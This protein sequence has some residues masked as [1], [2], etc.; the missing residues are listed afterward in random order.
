MDA[1]DID[2]S[3]PYC[4]YMPSP[5]FKEGGSFW[6]DLQRLDSQRM[7]SAS[8]KGHANSLFSS[9]KIREWDGKEL[10][11]RSVGKLVGER[12]EY[13]KNIAQREVKASIDGWS[14][15]FTWLHVPSNDMAACLV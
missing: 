11:D 10:Q 8:T 9:V 2:H 7:N 4:D 6:T 14:G 12:E 13:V 15:K 1:A 3:G 5:E